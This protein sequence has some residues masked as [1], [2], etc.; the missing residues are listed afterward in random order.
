MG[1][2]RCEW[3]NLLKS[4]IS[5]K[6]DRILDCFGIGIPEYFVNSPDFFAGAVPLP[7][8]QNDARMRSAVGHEFAM[9]SCIVAHVE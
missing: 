5:K 2:L 4:A 3:T 6:A 7:W 8:N 9:Q 1:R